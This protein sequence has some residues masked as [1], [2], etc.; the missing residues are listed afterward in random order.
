MK[1]RSIEPASSNLDAGFATPVGFGTPTGLQRHEP[2]PKA[3][4]D[5]FRPR[6][7]TQLCQQRRQ[8]VLDGVSGDTQLARNLLIPQ[9]VGHQPEHAQLAAG[10]RLVA[11]LSPEIES[12]TGPESLSSAGPSN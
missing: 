4:G 6:M 3:N 12:R 2:F 8:V 5:G 9:P 11:I 10:Q 7:D 1:F